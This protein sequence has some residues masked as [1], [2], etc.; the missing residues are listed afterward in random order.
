MLVF[1]IIISDIN[2]YTNYFIIPIIFNDR[3][4]P[5]NIFMVDTSS[6]TNL[7]YDGSVSILIKQLNILLEKI[8]DWSLEYLGSRNVIYGWDDELLLIYDNYQYDV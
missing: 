5:D 1:L 2:N 3:K 6:S 7:K 4:M 8:E